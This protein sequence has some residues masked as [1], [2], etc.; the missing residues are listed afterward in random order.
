MIVLLI[1]FGFVVAFCALSRKYQNPYLLTFVFGKKGAGKSL[2]MVREMKRD[3][4]KGWNVYCDMP[5]I[6]L[7][8][9]RIFNTD[10][11]GK[12]I[13]EPNSSIYIDEGGVKFD[14][15]NFKNF[16]PELR[17][18]F[19]Y[20]RKYKCKCMINS[21]TYDID[22]KIKA[23]VDRLALS[24]SIGNVFSWYRPIIKTIKFTDA[25]YT[26]ESKI[27]D[28]LKWASLWNWRFIYMP[29][30]HKYFD[31]FAAPARPF[32]DFTVFKRETPS[33]A[34]NDL[35]CSDV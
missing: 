35:E 11:L 12:F 28:Q 15:R 34:L 8:G 6:K 13:P 30:Y 27:C 31:S 23:C 10:D 24:R 14:N 16:P 33:A 22:L 4:K 9:V 17:D 5:D 32:L 1:I 21:Q 7:E 2:Y 25:N 20:M 29:R 26:G 3:L 18:F 19:K